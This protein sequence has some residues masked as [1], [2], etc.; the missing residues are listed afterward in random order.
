MSVRVE[1]SKEAQERAD[2]IIREKKQVAPAEAKTISPVEDARNDFFK[3]KRTEEINWWVGEWFVDYFGE[4]EGDRGKLHLAF[5]GLEAELEQTKKDLEKWKKGLD[6]EKRALFN[7]TGLRL[8]LEGRLAA[9]TKIMNEFPISENY[10]DN[11]EGFR[12]DV[13]SWFIK[14]SEAVTGEPKK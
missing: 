10:D 5:E 11:L 13:C 7:E 8:Q 9:T 1:R 4:K 12:Y 2:K 14:I 3:R 6:A